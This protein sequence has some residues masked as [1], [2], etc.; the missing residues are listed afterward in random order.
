VTARAD[1]GLAPSAS[2]VLKEKL[3]VTEATATLVVP[4]AQA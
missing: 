2:S 1:N 3:L 4:E